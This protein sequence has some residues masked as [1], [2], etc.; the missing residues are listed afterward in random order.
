MSGLGLSFTLFADRG[1]GLSDSPP[2]DFGLAARARDGATRPGDGLARQREGLV[3][4]AT[5][6]G[7]QA[8]HEPGSGPRRRDTRT[9]ACGYD[10][11]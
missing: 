10:K 3:S 2:P 1:L 7:G 6:G 9:S 8:W 4:C 5:G 11:V